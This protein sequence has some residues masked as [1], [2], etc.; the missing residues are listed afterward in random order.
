MKALQWLSESPDLI[1]IEMLWQDLKR[2]V[3]KQSTSNLNKLKKHC[4]MSQI[5]STTM[6]EADKVIQKRLVQVVAA[7]VGATSYWMM[8][9]AEVFH[10]LFGL[11]L[12]NN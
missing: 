7:K 12:I 8:E 11:V 1:L 9:C 5:S 3:H 2:A 10:T 6:W 4:R